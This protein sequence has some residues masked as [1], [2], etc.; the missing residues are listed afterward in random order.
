MDLV[1]AIGS[2]LKKQERDRLAGLQ[3]ST[4][5]HGFDAFGANAD[6]IAMGEVVTSPFYQAWF[7]VDSHGADNIP[8][9]GAA[10]LVSNHSGTLPF[11]GAM[12]WAD[13]LRRTNPP[14]VVRTVMD[15]FVPLLP[16]IGTLYTRVGAIA[17]GRDNVEAALAAGELVLIFPEGTE[18]IGKPFRERYRLQTWRVGHAELAIQCKAPIIPIAV[19]GAE[20]QMP[21]I[22]RIERFKVFGAPYVPIPLSLVPFPIRY[23]IYYGEPIDLSSRWSPEDAHRPQVIEEAAIIV[24]D[25]LQ[26]L[27]DQGLRRRRGLF[28]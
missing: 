17:G 2:L 27:I 25:R 15:H 6:W 5:G 19:I 16:F 8:K 20:E 21:E 13:V 9:R 7:R 3:L 18:G 23:H 10:V 14:R 28:S 24:K 11:D 12:I 1:R 22:A 4:L 26:S